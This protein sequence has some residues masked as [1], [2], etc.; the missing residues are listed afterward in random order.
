[1]RPAVKKTLGDLGLD[2]LDLYLMHWPIALKDG[3]NPF[4]KDEQGN[5]IYAYHDPCDTWK[6]MEALVDEGLV[7][8]IGNNSIFYQFTLNKSILRAGLLFKQSWLS[9]VP[10]LG[11]CIVSF[12]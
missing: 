7:R 11:H 8:A 5:L 9:S 10:G 2:Y 6:A 1:M 12:S 3:D 4:P